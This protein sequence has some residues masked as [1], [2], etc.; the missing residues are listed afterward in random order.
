MLDLGEDGLD[1]P[2]S[3]GV[4]PASV[5]AVDLGDGGCGELVGVAGAASAEDLIDTGHRDPEVLGGLVLGQFAGLGLVDDLAAALL[6]LGDLAELAGP[7]R[8]DERIHPRSRVLC[9][10]Q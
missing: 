9:S 6:G 2:G 8:C 3:S 10:L 7:A 5:G 4:G 1:G